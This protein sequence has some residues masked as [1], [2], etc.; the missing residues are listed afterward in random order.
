MVKGVVRKFVILHRSLMAMRMAPENEY[1]LACINLGNVD[2]LTL[3][4]SVEEES[5]PSFQAVKAV[6]K[7]SFSHPP[8]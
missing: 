4:G 3:N 8:A 6:L 7:I 1:A 5:P 2:M